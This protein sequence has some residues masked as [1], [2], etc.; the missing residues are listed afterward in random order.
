MGAVALKNDT[1]PVGFADWVDTG[2]ALVS[3]RD[4]VEWEL[5]DWLADGKARFGNQLDF[6]DTLGDKL[7]IAP[8]ELRGHVKIADAFPPHKRDT[9]LTFAHHEAVAILPPEEA[10]QVLHRAKSEHLDDRETRQAAIRRRAEIAPAL[11]PDTDWQDAEY[12]DLVRRW[13][14]SSREV[15]TMLIE[16]LEET[17][18][19]DIDL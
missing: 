16:Q 8:K 17:G 14:R 7:G 1:M 9:S 10:V 4:Q 2:R 6:F 13:N 12:R 18:L 11:I 19:A 5:V 3:R 15:R